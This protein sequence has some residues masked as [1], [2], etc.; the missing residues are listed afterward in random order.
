MD[1]LTDKPMILVGDGNNIVSIV[2]SMDV[3][4]WLRLALER[5][6]KEGTFNVIS[7]AVKIGKFIEKL[8]EKMD[9][10][11]PYGKVPFQIAYTFATLDEFLSSNPKITRFHVKALTSNRIISCEKAERLLGYKPIFDVERTVKVLLDGIIR[12]GRKG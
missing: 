3:A 6:G 11:N 9:I 1:M 12:I 4:R 10:E 7:F 5:D 2:H 8:A